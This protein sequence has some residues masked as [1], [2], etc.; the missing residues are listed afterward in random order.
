MC[1]RL[2]SNSAARQTLR[3]LCDVANAAL[4]W[5]RSGF[6]LRDHIRRAGPKQHSTF[7]GILVADILKIVSNHGR[8]W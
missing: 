3:M 8:T 1:L 2:L 5:A 6:L 4:C 7:D